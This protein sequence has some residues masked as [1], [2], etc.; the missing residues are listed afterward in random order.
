MTTPQRGFTLIEL[1]VV[2]AIIGILAT[3][4]M[5]SLGSARDSA[6]DARRASDLRQLQRAFELFANDNRGL[7]PAS[8]TNTQVV[9]MNTGASNITPYID[10]IPTDPT[11][12]GNNGYRYAAST[13][14]VSYTLLVRLDKNTTWCSLN[15]APGYPAWN[16]ISSDGGGSNYPPCDFQ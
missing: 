2:I 4:I 10:P 11:N 7:F 9:N 15:Y 14:R 8:P 5:A 6:Q 13:D 3:V 16:G 12:T 1:L